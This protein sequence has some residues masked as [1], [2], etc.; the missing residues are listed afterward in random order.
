MGLFRALD[1]A[2]LEN[3]PLTYP[4]VGSTRSVEAPPG[5]RRAQRSA[6]VGSGRAAFERAAAAVLDWQAQ[7]GAGLRVQAGGPAGTPGTVVVLDVGLPGLGYGIP[8]RV[9]CA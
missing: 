3:A 8:C 6:V 1:P 7:R 2:G 4:G 5:F 9:V